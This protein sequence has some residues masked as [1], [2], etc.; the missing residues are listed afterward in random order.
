MDNRIKILAENIVKNSLKV[1]PGEK[2]LI[3]YIKKL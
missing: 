1:N 3:E 2:V